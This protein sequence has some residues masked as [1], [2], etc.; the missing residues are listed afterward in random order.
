MVP[1]LPIQNSVSVV[2]KN[3]NGNGSGMTPAGSIVQNSVFGITAF[4]P[5]S[6]HALR[7]GTVGLVTA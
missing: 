7:N 6:E 1:W 3:V 2:P 5:G 4:L